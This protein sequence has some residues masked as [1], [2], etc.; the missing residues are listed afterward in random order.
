M[1]L[2]SALSD[3]EDLRDADRDA[4][5]QLMEQNYA[6]IRRDN[7]DSDLDAKTWVILV[8]CPAT[9]RL[10]G[11]ST[12]VMLEQ[13]VGDDLVQALYSGDTVMDRDH[14]GDPA[15][16]HAWGHF[17]L[18]RIDRQIEGR[19]LF[20]LLTSKG[21]RTYRYLPLFFRHFFPCPEL[22]T[23]SWE[24]SVI[25]VLGERVGRGRYDP[26]RQIIRAAVDKDYVRPEFAEPGLR[27]STDPHVRFFVE[28]NPD[29]ARGD[30]LCCVAPLTRENFTRA[31]W[32]VIGHA[33][34]RLRTLSQ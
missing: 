32:R 24:Q 12:Q 15:L 34:S 4:M 5:F 8:H 28:S 25:D 29:Y 10:V 23:P 19:P 14:W 2:S 27:R 20:W 31:A 6:N 17:A 16:A 11:F 30:E 18:Q 1:R 26:S 9:Q 7:F 33:S 22:A 3:V 13:R 21:F